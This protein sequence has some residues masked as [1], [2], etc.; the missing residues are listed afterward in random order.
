MNALSARVRLV[1]GAY[2]EP[3]AVAYQHKSDVDAATS[4]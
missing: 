4:G 3:K 1:K 2:K